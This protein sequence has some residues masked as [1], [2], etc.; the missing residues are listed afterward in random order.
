MNIKQFGFTLA[1]V[2]ITLGIIGI[3]AALTMPTLITSYQKKEASVKL[4][5]TYTIFNQA[6]ENAKVDYGDISQWEYFPFN[7]QL[8][9]SNT[10]KI[11]TNFVQSYLSPYIKITEDCG[12]SNTKKCKDETVCNK[13]KT[14]CLPFSKTNGYYFIT[15]TARYSIIPNQRAGEINRPEIIVY[16]DINGNSKPNIYGR[17]VFE[18]YINQKEQRFLFSGNDK[19]RSELLENGCNTKDKSKPNCGYLIELD[20]W[21][22]KKDYPW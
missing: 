7:E 10:Q 13:D 21:E 19:T 17:D 14:Y 9:S 6:I 22:I 5:Q 3:V 2:L 1:E 16:I 12:I 11:L 20:G 18:G 15:P 4:K 8:T